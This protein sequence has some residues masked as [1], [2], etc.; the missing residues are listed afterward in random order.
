MSE[1]SSEFDHNL[2]KDWEEKQDEKKKRWRMRKQTIYE[3]DQKE[4]MR[5]LENKENIILSRIEFKGDN[6]VGYIEWNQKK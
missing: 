4:V 5:L 3:W 6:I 1:E 2:K